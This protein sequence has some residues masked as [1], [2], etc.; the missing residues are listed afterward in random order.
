MRWIHLASGAKPRPSQ[1]EERAVTLARRAQRVWRFIVSKILPIWPQGAPG[2]RG[3]GREHHPSLTHFPVA[4]GGDGGASMLVL[5]GGGYG[6]LSAHEGEDYARWLA[7]RGVHAAVLD[8]RL[9]S[10]G[11]QHPDMLQDAARALRCLRTEARKSGRDPARVGVMGS[12]AGGHLAAT[13]S[14][15]FAHPDAADPIGD[16]SGGESARPDLT[17]LCYPVVS[18]DPAITH[19]GSRAGVLGT[20]PTAERVR[21][22]SAEQQVRRE[23][24][25]AFVWHTADDELV[26]V[27]NAVAYAEACWRVGVECALHV[28]PR[29]EHGLG[30]G[31]PER[32]APPW[33]AL[34][35]CW[36]VARGWM[37]NRLPPRGESPH[38]SALA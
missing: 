31:R 13:L 35:E 11:Y 29:G 37:V 21:L 7:A 5:P 1:T 14:T 10:Q 8:Y 16:S 23:T 17:V 38:R 30:L 22:L 19:A 24:P 32:P 36:L 34:L 20:R 28:F 26:P 2:A 27:A 25:P 6:F 4:W 9:A 3:D 15:L 12:S 33:S 18:L